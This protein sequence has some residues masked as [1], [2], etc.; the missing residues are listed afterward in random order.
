MA[1]GF[2]WVFM[3]LI[4]IGLFSISPILGICTLLFCGGWITSLD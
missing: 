3:G 4:V 1:V 2:G